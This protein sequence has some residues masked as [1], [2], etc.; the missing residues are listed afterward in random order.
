VPAFREQWWGIL[1]GVVSPDELE[2]RI[3]TVQQ[4][5][6]VVAERIREELK[7]EDRSALGFRRLAKAVCACSL[8]ASGLSLI[9]YPVLAAISFALA[10]ASY[11]PLMNAAG[12]SL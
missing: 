8:L 4:Y 11:S 9:P 12:R 7:A 5:E 3:E 10:V 2:A 6:R 1:R